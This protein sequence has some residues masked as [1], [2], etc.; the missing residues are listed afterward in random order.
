MSEDH[1]PT[2]EETQDTS[3]G[4]PDEGHAHDETQSVIDWQKRYEDLRPQFDRTAQEKAQYEALVD[5]LTDPDTQAEA[6]AA[7]GIEIDDD[8]EEEDLLA[9]PTDHLSSR[10]EQLEARL[11][12]RAEAEQQFAYQEAV[13]DHVATEIASLEQKTGEQFS[14]EE[15]QFLHARAATNPDHN[16]LPDVQSAWQA[17]DGVWQARQRKYIESKR[18]PRI[19]GG[20]SATQAPDLSTEQARAEYIDGR[21]SE[22]DLIL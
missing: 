11:A 20:Q 3:A 9:D 22:A 10:I 1:Q 16:G 6:L 15:I 7:F 2:P 18:A 5:S 19:P 13:T 12:Q 4:A 17:L 21:L 8:D 14:A